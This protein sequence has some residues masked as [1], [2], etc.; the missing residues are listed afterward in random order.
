MPLLFHVESDIEETEIDQQS[1]VQTDDD[2][3]IISKKESQR[4]ITNDLRGSD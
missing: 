2:D 4:N 3:F 1:S